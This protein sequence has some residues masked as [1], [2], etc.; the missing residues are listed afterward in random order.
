MIKIVINGREI[1]N[2]VTKF[3]ILTGFAFILA[4]IGAIVVFVL[5]PLLGIA[6]ALSAG[7]FGILFAA[8]VVGVLVLVMVS[9][10]F[11]RFGGPAEFHVYKRF[12]K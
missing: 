5:L 10:V 11:D 6:I 12:R 7:L 4:L 1:T 9:V 8:I 2:P 3:L